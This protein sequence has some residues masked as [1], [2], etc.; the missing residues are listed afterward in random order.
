MARKK[1]S[2]GA[3]RRLQRGFAVLALLLLIAA[4]AIVAVLDRRVTKQFEGRRWTLP[5]RVYAQPID[6]YAGQQLSAQRVVAEL[7]RLGYLAVSDP[8][9]PGTY[10]RRGQEISVPG[11]GGPTCLTRPLL[12]RA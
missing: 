5:A 7:E 10:R 3:R 2:A 11:D 12:R 6:L 8:D 9:R 1:L 4:I